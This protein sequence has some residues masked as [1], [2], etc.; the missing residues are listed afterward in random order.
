MRAHA[1][2][3]LWGVASAPASGVLRE[4]SHDSDPRD[5]A[6]ALV[7]RH[8]TGASDIIAILQATALHLDPKARAAGAFAMGQTRHADC[9]SA[10]RN[11]L[12]DR[13]PNVRSEAL[14]ALIQLQ[15]WSARNEA[16]PPVQSGPAA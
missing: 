13:D 9:K 14:Q 12:K 1:V 4:A 8:Y 3:S 7:G 6:N 15:R 11:L 10:P 2:T 16:A 5:A